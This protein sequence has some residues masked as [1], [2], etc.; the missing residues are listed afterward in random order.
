MTHDDMMQAVELYE[1]KNESNEKSTV[2]VVKSFHIAKILAT[3]YEFF[4]YLVGI[5]KDR[6]D[7]EQKKHIWIFR[8]LPEVEDVFNRLVAEAGQARL[9]RSKLYGK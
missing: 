3:D 8:R 5:A 9:D 2:I 1:Q 4:N 7:P 6:Y